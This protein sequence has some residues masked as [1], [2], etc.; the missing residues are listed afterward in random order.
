MDTDMGIGA[1]EK[2][3]LSQLRILNT[4]ALR[5]FGCLLYNFNTFY[6]VTEDLIPDD[7]PEDIAKAIKARAT[8]LA[9]I[10]DGKPTIAFYNSFI[11]ECDVEELTFVNL[12]EILHILNKDYM[13]GD[14]YPDKELHNLA[15]DHIHNCAL[16]HDIDKGIIRKVKCPESAFI[17]TEL[18]DKKDYTT[19]AEVYNWLVDNAVKHGGI[20]TLGN[21]L[22]VYKLTINGKERIVVQDIGRNG[23]EA[24]DGE[25]AEALQA[26]ARTI[27]ETAS[28]LFKGDMAGSAVNKLIE[29]IIAVE[30]PWT[31]LLDKSIS[32]KLIPDDCNRSWKGL[33]KRPFALGLMYPTDDVMEKPSKLILLEDQSGSITQSDI[34]K[35]ASILL[36]SIRYFDEVWIMRHDVR[37]HHNKVYQSN[38]TTE[39]DLS[40]EAGGR[41][42][43]SHKYVFQEIQ[44]AFED[45]DDL[46]LVIMLTDFYSDIEG[47]WKKFEWCKH[48]PVTIVCN[49]TKEIPPYIDRAPIY[50][51]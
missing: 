33:Q 41:G 27:L 18:V 46:S 8:A 6:L 25:I 20:Q 50:I 14:T 29:K 42:G 43:T 4:N 34:R 23:V 15:A 47:L 31:S 51:K 19:I 36:Q 35:F 48:I 37:I 5:L 9:T 45:G 22:T 11:D 44:E 38:Q 12:H 26:E 40:F 39:E 17:I 32:Q 7:C 49:S 21:G 28:E 10:I 30:I 16:K 13:A 1:K 3:N 2:L 24:V